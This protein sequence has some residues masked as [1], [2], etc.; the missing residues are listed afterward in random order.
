MLHCCSY[1]FPS[2]W[3][4][5]DLNLDA[6]QH[7]PAAVVFHPWAEAVPSCCFQ[8]TLRVTHKV[9]LWLLLGD[10]IK[11]GEV[12]AVSLLGSAA[13]IKQQAQKESVCRCCRA[14]RGTESVIVTS[15]PHSCSETQ[16]LLPAWAIFC[17]GGSFSVGCS[18]QH[19]SPE[20]RFFFHVICKDGSRL[21]ET[22]NYQGTW[23]ERRVYDGNHL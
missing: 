1:M 20:E 8:S 13:L 10:V 3:S 7:R 15:G 22:D 11:L 6:G 2:T 14:M 4:P 18:A 23:V 5:I 19:A 16:N 21:Q 12:C 9:L 17:E